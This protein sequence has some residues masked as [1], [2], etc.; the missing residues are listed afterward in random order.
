MRVTLRAV[1]VLVGLMLPACASKTAVP[2]EEAPVLSTFAPDLRTRIVDRLGID[3]VRILETATAFDVTL[4]R[5]NDDPPEDGTV[6]ARRR[7]EVDDE[8]AQLVQFFYDV[9][10]SND[11]PCKCE[12]VLSYRVTTTDG[13]AEARVIG[14]PVS[15]R[16]D[17]RTLMQVPPLRAKQ[18]LSSLVPEPAPMSQP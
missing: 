4:H 10:A 14:H 8:R 5:A 16:V 3:G 9:A 17:Q 6:I 2:D 13:S 7:I 1:A 15:V 18:T 12:P 11:P